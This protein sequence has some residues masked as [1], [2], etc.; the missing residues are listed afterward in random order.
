MPNKNQDDSRIVM[1]DPADNNKKKLEIR[2][3]GNVPVLYTDLV[4]VSSDRMGLVLNF[5]QGFGPTHQ[6]NVVARLGM[7]REHAKS[8][9]E[10]LKKELEK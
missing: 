4:L 2:M 8:L 5:T 1:K 10:A 9:L 6:K 7:S 3:P